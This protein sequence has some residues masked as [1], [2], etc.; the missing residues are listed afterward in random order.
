MPCLGG[1]FSLLMHP[2]RRGLGAVAMVMNHIVL[3]TEVSTQGKP[4]CRT[5]IMYFTAS[6]NPAAPIFMCGTKLNT[7]VDDVWERHPLM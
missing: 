2:V 4:R 3:K 5:F 7:S 1:G 6:L